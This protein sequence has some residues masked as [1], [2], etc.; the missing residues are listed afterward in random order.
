M[1]ANPCEVCNK[2]LINHAVS[3]ITRDA[4]KPM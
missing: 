2:M 4:G 1:Q 3:N